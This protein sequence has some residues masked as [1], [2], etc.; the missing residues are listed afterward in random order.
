MPEECI[1]VSGVQASDDDAAIDEAIRQ[2]HF[3]GDVDPMDVTEVD[4]INTRMNDE[5]ARYDLEVNYIRGGER[6]Q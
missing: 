3:W 5:G 2:A 1:K 6:T 4:I